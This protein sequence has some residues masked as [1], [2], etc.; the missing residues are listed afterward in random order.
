MNI[1]YDEMVN[2]VLSTPKFVPGSGQDNPREIL[3]KLGNPQDKFKHVGLGLNCLGSQDN[4]FWNH[5]AL[6]RKKGNR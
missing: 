2:I 4:P 3:E 5:L 1:T 6:S